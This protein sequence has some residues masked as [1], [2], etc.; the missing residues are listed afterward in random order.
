MS[1]RLITWNVAGRG[2]RVRDQLVYLR[3]RSPDVVALQEVTPSTSGAVID[4]LEDVVG[5]GNSTW[6]MAPD[7]EVSS[8]R[9]S[10]GVLIASRQPIEGRASHPIASPWTDKTLSVEVRLHDDLV[11]LHTVHVPPGSSNGWVKIDVLEAVGSAL[12]RPSSNPVILAGDLNTP[13]VE[14]TSGEVVTW[15]QRRSREGEWVV[16]R[17]FRGGSGERWDRAERGLLRGRSEHGLRDALRSHHGHELQEASWVLRR[18]DR[19]WRRR[20]DHILVSDAIEIE[21]IAYDHEP[22]EDGLSDHS[23][24]EM[25]FEIRPKAK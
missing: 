6:S 3:S 17:R 13:K 19:E 18:G 20:F 16:R 5:L 7:P 15:A 11:D 23:P 8:R 14:L 4:G 22:R 25:D 2:S 1:P 9:R 12:R 24:L 10:L 21:R